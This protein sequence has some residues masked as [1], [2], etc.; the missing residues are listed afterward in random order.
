[1]SR[2]TGKGSKFDASY[3]LLV[4]FVLACLA[5][6]FACLDSVRNDAGAECY[7]RRN[8]NPTMNFRVGVL[9]CLVETPDGWFVADRVLGDLGEYPGQQQ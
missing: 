1:V 2:N 9:S 8:M 4:I 6:I 3:L 5:G 7:H